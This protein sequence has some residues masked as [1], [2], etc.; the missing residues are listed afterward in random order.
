MQP[1]KHITEI[2][3]TAWTQIAPAIRNFAG[4]T[5]TPELKGLLLHMAEAAEAMP[6]L[7]TDPA[8]NAD[9]LDK[10]GQLMEQNLHV[11]MLPS[12]LTPTYVLLSV[13]YPYLRGLVTP[14]A[15][16]K[17]REVTAY[18][19]WRAAVAQQAGS[20]TAMFKVAEAGTYFAAAAAADTAPQISKSL[21]AAYAKI[22]S[23]Y[24]K[25]Y[26]QDK[27]WID[28]LAAEIEFKLSC[29]EMDQS[30]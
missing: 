7:L 10:L 9:K 13:A 16:W 8:G 21:T 19:A 26:D 24:P 25:L 28:G 30:A 15:V 11:R 3:K 17:A 27:T 18:Y 29:L 12:K 2:K 23:V 14:S 6:Q 1:T 5:A 4:V 22:A 20:R